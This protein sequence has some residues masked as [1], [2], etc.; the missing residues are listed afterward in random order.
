[1]NVPTQRDRGWFYQ[2]FTLALLESK[3]CIG[4]HWFKYLDNDPDDLTT[5]PSNRDSNKGIV[6]LRY[7]P[8]VELV[9]AMKSLNANIY[10]L[11]DHF[12]R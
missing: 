10:P 1:L 3:N 9:A 8:Y 4:W 7:E 6:N 2:N 5:D 12:D 11:A